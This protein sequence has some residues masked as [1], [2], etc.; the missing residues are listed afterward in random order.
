MGYIDFLNGGVAGPFD[1][2]EYMAYNETDPHSS[3]IHPNHLNQI[4]PIVII[5]GGEVTPHQ[6]GTFLYN[7]PLR[8]FGFWFP[9]GKVKIFLLP[10]E[11]KENRF[12]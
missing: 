3:P 6:D 7:E 4:L 1:T 11:Q 2:L 8:L 10:L 5:L 12:T 9:I